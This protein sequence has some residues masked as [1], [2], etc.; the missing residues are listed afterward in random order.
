M[1]IGRN[2]SGIFLLYKGLFALFYIYILGCSHSFQCKQY[3]TWYTEQDFHARVYL[4]VVM[5]LIAAPLAALWDLGFSDVAPTSHDPS[6]CG[7]LPRRSLAC[8]TII[9]R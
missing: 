1:I 8:S 9:G 2:V 4:A 7:S 6:L 3:P 5:L